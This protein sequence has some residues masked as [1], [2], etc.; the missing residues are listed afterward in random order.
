MVQTLAL[1]YSQCSHS[2]VTRHTAWRR[3]MLSSTTHAFTYCHRLPVYGTSLYL[4]IHLPILELTL[5]MLRPPIRSEHSSNYTRSVCTTYSSPPSI[6]HKW[7]SSCICL[8]GSWLKVYV[9]YSWRMGS[10]RLNHEP[11]LVDLAAGSSNHSETS[12]SK[13]MRSI[14]VA[15][16]VT[17]ARVTV[18]LSANEPDVRKKFCVVTE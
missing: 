17:N 16:H 14:C 6:D 18:H 7:C 10:P 12:R 1:C 15:G 9:R 4:S 13:T 8:A 5:I 11:C 2:D 3:S